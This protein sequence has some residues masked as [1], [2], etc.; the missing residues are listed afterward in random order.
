MYKEQPLLEEIE[1]VEQEG[2]SGCL[3]LRHDDQMVEIHFREGSVEAVSSNLP[4]HRLGQ[5][6]LRGEFLDSPKLDKLLR[7]SRRQKKA[8]G[9]IALRSKIL[10]ASQLTGVIYSQASA[11]LGFCLGNGFQI[12]SFETASPSFHF[13]VPLNL[14]SLLL[15]R[16][17]DN[18]ESLALSSGQWLR[19]RRDKGISLMPWSP[20]E[21]SVLSHL[22]APKTLES[23][24]SAAGIQESE[25]KKILEVLYE[26]GFVEVCE[27]ISRETSSFAEKETLPLEVLIPEIRNPAP[28]DKLEVLKNKSSFISEQF[29]SLKVQIE[30]MAV[31][32]PIQ[33]ISVCGAYMK[34]GKSLVASNLAMSYAQ[35]PGRR[36]ILLDCDLRNPNIQKYLGVPLESG[37]INYLTD[38]GLEPYCYMRRIGSLFFMTSGGITDNAVELLSHS[39]M[40]ELMDYLRKEFDTVVL[41]SAPLD[42]VPDTRILFK[43]VDGIVM[44]IRRAKTPFRSVERVFK[45]LDPDKLL[46]VVFNDVKPQRFNTYSQYGYYHSGK[47]RYP[48][49]SGKVREDK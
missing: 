47:G 11:L 46:G 16:A 38:E 18:S 7:K 5:Y 29:A 44:V 35:D 27:G 4:R 22:N 10:D 20:R 12:S 39:R 21:L 41:D 43:L 31:A 42:L 30:G 3:Q 13:S 36:V 37:I 15:E 19:L 40:N 14:H 25:V 17:R 45:A 33:V 9:E 32:R 8:L 2:R 23:L 26:L 28:D 6:L 34:D 1:R 49:Y 48:Y 24:A